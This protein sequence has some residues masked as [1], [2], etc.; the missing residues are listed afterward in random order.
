MEGKIA[1]LPPNPQRRLLLAWTS[2]FTPAYLFPEWWPLASIS[3]FQVVAHQLVR[4]S[5][6]DYPG[7]L[8]GGWTLYSPVV[9]PED[10]YVLEVVDSQT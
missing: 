3:P 4:L 2:S 8:A 1:K 9:G 7:I 5:A 10:Y 6:E